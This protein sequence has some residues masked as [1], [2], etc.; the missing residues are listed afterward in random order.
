MV[1][2]WSAV[3]WVASPSS[4]PD[5]EVGGGSACHVTVTGP[6]YQD[7]LQGEVTPPAVQVAEMLFARAGAAVTTDPH[8]AATTATTPHLILIAAAPPPSDAAA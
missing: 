1:L 7:E 5:T 3:N 8:A 6:W 4:H 2:G